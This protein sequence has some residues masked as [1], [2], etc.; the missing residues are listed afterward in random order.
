MQDNFNNKDENLIRNLLAVAPKHCDN[1][2]SKY[3]ENNFKVVKTSPSNT[4]FHLKCVICG[5][6]YMLNVINPVNGMIGAQRTPINID[7][8]LGDEIQ[9]FA[10][11]PSVD[12]DEAIDVYNTL[13]PSITEDSLKKL[14]Q[15]S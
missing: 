13:E 3:S 7:L 4:V 9:K 8:E 2:G 10:G 15:T 14:L 5:N 12:K 11:R 1:C 6:A